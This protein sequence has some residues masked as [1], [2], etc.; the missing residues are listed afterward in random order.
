MNNSA[1]L[2]VQND[3]TVKVGAVDYILFVLI[4]QLPFLQLLLPFEKGNFILVF[5]LLFW[6]YIKRVDLSIPNRIIVLFFAYLGLCLAQGMYFGHFSTM[7]LVYSFAYIFF[8]PFLLYRIYGFKAIIIFERVI[9]FFTAL[10]LSI[11]FLHQISPA[12]KQMIVDL[13]E[14]INNRNDR[15]LHRFMMI[16]TYWPMLDTELG[17][18]RNAGF[19]GE[20]AT[21]CSFIILGFAIHESTNS[22]KFSLKSA[23]YIIALLSSL[24]TTGYSAL[25]IFLL[26][27]LIRMK[28]LLVRL[29]IFPLFV[30]IF[31][32]VFSSLDFMEKKIS[33][34]YEDGTSVEL[35]SETSGR[36]LGIRKS[37]YVMFKYPFLGRGLQAMTRPTRMDDP[38]YADYGFLSIL[39]KYGLVFGGI[40]F[41][42][43]L[44]GM[45]YF[46]SSMGVP[47]V[48][49]WIYIVSLLVTLL[50]QQG[51]YDIYFMIFFI[52]GWLK[53][54]YH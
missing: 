46:F 28:S 15:E 44:S 41:I 26:T 45:I 35:N 53:F 11:W 16:Y 36:I 13:I 6:A 43:F 34:Q 21:F 37:V 54:N 9:Y 5:G 27:Y 39:S 47:S 19:S 32:Y 49:Y 33:K 20:P 2:S 42:L 3:D 14:L 1:Y 23:V 52:M 48:N 38:E 10:S 17:I 7:T 24:S 25:I 30:F 4:I 8:A 51:M 40:F 50:A 22:R 31:F 18:S 12:F 29:V